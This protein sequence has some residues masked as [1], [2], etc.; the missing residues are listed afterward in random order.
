MSLSIDGGARAAPQPYD[1]RDRIVLALLGAGFIASWTYVFLHPSDAA[2][3]TAIGGTG[4]WTCGF[5]WICIR[6]SKTPDAN[7]CG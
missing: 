3:A 5:H 4:A 6:D 2:F 7:P 1:V